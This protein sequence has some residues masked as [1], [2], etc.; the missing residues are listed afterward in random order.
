VLRTS[1]WNE[2]TSVLIASGFQKKSGKSMKYCSRV[3]GPPFGKCIADN[4]KAD[5]SHF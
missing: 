1:A 2:A 4:V 3:V 5:M